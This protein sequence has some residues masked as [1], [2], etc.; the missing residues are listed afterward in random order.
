MWQEAVYSTSD[1]LEGRYPFIQGRATE[2]SVGRCCMMQL[3]PPPVAWQYDLFMSVNVYIRVCFWKQ[4]VVSF[5]L[6][7][8]NVHAWTS[9]LVWL[10]MQWLRSAYVIVKMKILPEYHDIE[11]SMANHLGRESG[12][13]LTSHQWAGALNNI[14]NCL[15]SRA[16]RL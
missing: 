12:L 10:M 15:A 14:I 6:L 4:W 13:R 8:S 16:T 3:T 1:T 9:R 11:D 7:F 2:E 5:V